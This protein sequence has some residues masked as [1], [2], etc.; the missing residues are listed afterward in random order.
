M[1]GYKTQGLETGYRAGHRAQEQEK[2][3][4]RAQDKKFRAWGQ[5]TD[6]EHREWGRVF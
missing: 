2:I 5:E 3:H 6:K 1:T 4:N